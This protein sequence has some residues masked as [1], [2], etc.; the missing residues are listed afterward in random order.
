[1]DGVKTEL[2]EAGKPMETNY[3]WMEAI[4]VDGSWMVDTNILIDS[5]VDFYTKLQ[6]C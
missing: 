1:M 2:L 3:Q 6:I 5:K 4:T